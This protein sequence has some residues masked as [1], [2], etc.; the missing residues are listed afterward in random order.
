MWSWS[1]RRVDG[2]RVHVNR[3]GKG[4]EDDAAGLRCGV[5]SA[6]GINPVDRTASSPP[7]VKPHTNTNHSPKHFSPPR[8]RPP[9]P[10]PARSSG[11]PSNKM[12]YGRPSNFRASVYP[13]AQLNSPPSP[14]PARAYTASGQPLTPAMLRLLD[15]QKENQAFERIAQQAEGLKELFGSFG[16]Q[17]VNAQEGSKGQS[18]GWIG[19]KARRATDFA[20]LSDRQLWL[21]WWSIG[22]MCS[23]SPTSPWVSRPGRSHALGRV[24]LNSPLHP[25]LTRFS[26]PHLHPRYL[27]APFNSFA[28]SQEGP[29]PCRLG[30]PDPDPP[31]RH[32]PRPDGA[33]SDRRRRPGRWQRRRQFGLLE[34]VH[35]P[36]SG[37]STA[38]HPARSADDAHPVPR[39]TPHNATVRCTSG[40]GRQSA[41]PESAC[42]AAPAS[43]IPATHNMYLTLVTHIVTITISML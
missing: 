39:P 31:A 10:D 38:S 43:S 36:L 18:G 17:Y 26:P 24:A 30:R 1:C 15:K 35:F 40:A 19:C 5:G 23:G 12:E 16:E 41:V 6:I 9:T 28:R 3:K 11:R 33:D 25:P 37:Q 34:R 32:A 27:P 4:P 42:S 20:W 13:T 29:S 14:P 21:R 7:A 2:L 8:P 22:R